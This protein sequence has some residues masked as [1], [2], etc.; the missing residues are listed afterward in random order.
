[1]K[2]FMPFTDI[3]SSR[4]NIRDFRR[5]AEQP[6]ATYEQAYSLIYGE[7]NVPASLYNLIVAHG[8]YVPGEQQNPVRAADDRSVYRARFDGH[9]VT[10][11]VHHGESRSHVILSRRPSL[12]PDQI[13]QRIQ[14][15]KQV[16]YTEARVIFH[17]G[18]GA[19]EKADFYTYGNDEMVIPHAYS[20]ESALAGASNDKYDYEEQQIMQIGAAE[21]GEIPP[22][23]RQHTGRAMERRDVCQTFVHLVANLSQLVTHSAAQLA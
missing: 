9:A 22:I 5:A 15:R 2:T 12:V 17:L 1:M 10:G 6:I 8:K 3:R 23:L 16:D 19:V 4:Q 13:I 11:Q 18:A 20:I 21:F 14:R 7:Y